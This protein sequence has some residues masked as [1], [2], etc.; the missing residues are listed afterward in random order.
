MA[1]HSKKRHNMEA[2]YKVNLQ[3]GDIEEACVDGETA[4]FSTYAQANTKRIQILNAKIAQL[5]IELDRLNEALE[6]AQNEAQND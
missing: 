5:E 6:N 2:Y 3:S 1:G 4:W